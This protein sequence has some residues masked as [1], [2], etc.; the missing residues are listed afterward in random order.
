[1]NTR[2]NTRLIAL[3]VVLAMLTVPLGVAA[4]GA[5]DIAQTE[6]AVANESTG[7]DDSDDD[8]DTADGNASPG[9]Q[10]GGAIGVQ[11]AGLDGDLDD[12]RFGLRIAAAD[13]DAERADIIEE[14]I[15]NLERRQA[16]HEERLA[17]LDAARGAGEMSE[18]AYQAR[19]AA[20]VAES[21]A[22]ERAAA[23]TASSANDLPEERLAERG[24]NVTALEQLRTNAAGLG[25]ERASETAR[26][27]AGESVRTPGWTTAVGDRTGDAEPRFDNETVGDDTVTTES[28]PTE[29]DRQPGD[30]E[31]A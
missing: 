26:D 8:R 2:L 13:S 21:G 14:R 17:E 16:A 11:Q 31:R 18:S 20:L 1:M 12:R 24:I 7:D 10:L 3:L 30:R 22:T 4:V 19:V 9:A 6:T 27:I 5:D 25:G 29:S 23:Q 15:E 28:E